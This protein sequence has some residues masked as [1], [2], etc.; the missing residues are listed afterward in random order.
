[1]KGKRLVRQAQA[2]MGRLSAAL[3]RGKSLQAF[4]RMGKLSLRCILVR[5]VRQQAADSV[6]H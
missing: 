4:F 1:V 3:F 2:A 6:I 5:I